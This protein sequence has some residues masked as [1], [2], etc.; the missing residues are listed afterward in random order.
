MNGKANYKVLN[1]KLYLRRG[2]QCGC[3]LL[4]PPTIS[5]RNIYSRT[6]MEIRDIGW[7]CLWWEDCCYATWSKKDKI[8][9]FSSD[10]IFLQEL[11]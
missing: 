7:K 9:A 3:R 5:K 2:K 10:M 8:Y 6:T 1:L 4:I 11:P